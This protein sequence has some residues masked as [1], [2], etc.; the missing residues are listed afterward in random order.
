MIQA[1]AGTLPKTT[2]V[3]F[4]LS[5]SVPTADENRPKSVQL[6]LYIQ[7]ATSGSS[8]GMANWGDFMTQL[9]AKA[10]NSLA[11]CP[12]NLDFV[13]DSWRSAD[14]MSWYRLYRSGWVEQGGFAL[15]ATPVFNWPMPFLDLNYSVSVSTYRTN[16]D[17]QFTGGGIVCSKTTTGISAV[18]Y[19]SSQVVNLAFFG[20]GFA[21]L[22]QEG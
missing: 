15:R 3:T 11:S 9:E 4:D 19:T 2:R 1:T 12:A 16:S 8:P 21:N 6:A 17:A 5:T 22:T 18:N 7:V 14:Q 20:C 10:D 13:V